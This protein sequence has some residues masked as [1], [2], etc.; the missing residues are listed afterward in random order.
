MGLG[1]KL[2]GLLAV[3]IVVGCTQSD[4]QQENKQKEWALALHGGA[5][6]ISEDRP[7][8]VKQAYFDDLDEALTIGEDI[9]SSGGSAEDAVEK[10]INY[11]EDNPRFNAGKG[12]VFTHDGEHELDA[13]FMVGNTREAGTVTGVKTVKN[14]ITL[15]R[16]VM[17]TSEHVMFATEGA[18]RYA[19]K[20]G[21]ERVDQ[22]YFYTESR[23][24]ALQRALEQ[25]EEEDGK[26]SSLIPD[27]DKTALYADGEKFGTVGAVAVDKDG[28]IVAGTS[29]GGMT[30]KKFGRVGDVPI[31][32]SGT[33][34][35][36]V[37]AVSMTGWGEKIMRAVSG[38]T[39]SAYMKYKPAT[40]KEA[41]DYLLQD[42]LNPGE[43]GM[44]AVDK[45]GN[46]YMD[47]NT[48]G[49]FRG[50]SDSEGNREVAI[51]D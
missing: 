13:A 40:L 38:H 3:L 47:M 20:V 30:N 48:N 33:Y 43:A 37:V 36:D 19:D 14:P 17:E 29:T 6:A 7:D 41:G 12:A 31:I 35:S 2:I 8:S 16:K 45:Y 23:Y 42:V 4:A 32:G 18:E 27:E 46:I 44:I 26:Q 39:V 11:L 10:V 9:L 5:G 1:K 21:V 28:Q 15:A 25:E 50:S 34:A 24:K 49:M 51:W 22:D